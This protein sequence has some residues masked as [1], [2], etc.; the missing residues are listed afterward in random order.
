MKNAVIIS[1]FASVW[2]VPFLICGFSIRFFNKKSLGVMVAK[3]FDLDAYVLIHLL[4]SF[5]K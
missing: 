1:L 5:D 2:F 4:I 3:A